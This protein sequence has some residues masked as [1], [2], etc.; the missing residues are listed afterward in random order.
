M[1]FNKNFKIILMIV[2]LFGFLPQAIFAS[3]TDGTVSGS[4]WSDQIG[5]VNFGTT[6]GNVH[7]TDSALTGYAWNE[8][9]GRINLNPTKSG[10]ANTTAGM[11]SGY[12]FAEGT[13]WINFSA[14][15]I[16]C[17]GKFVG[18]ATGD[19]IDT[20]N[21][22]CS[23]CNMY[24]D[25][26]PSSGCGNSGPQP[27]PYQ[28]PQE[29]A[30][31]QEP[32]PDTIVLDKIPP[33]IKITSIKDKYATNEEI[34]IAG[35][36]EPNAEVIVLIGDS[37]G[38]FSANEKGEWFITLGKLPEGLYHLE[39]TPRDLAGNIGKTI[40]DDFLVERLFIKPLEEKKTT[41]IPPFGPILRQLAEKLKPLIPKFFQQAAKPLPMPVVTVPK[42][43]QPSLKYAWRLLPEKPIARFVLAPLPQ[44]VKLLAQKF[45]EVGKTFSAVGVSK[46]AN[47]QKIKNSKLSLPTL[48]ETA[49]LTS[50]E[51][52]AGKIS[53][54]KA[55]PLA[56]MSAIAK[57][58]IPTDIVFLKAGGGFIDINVALSINNQG[59]SEQRIK[60]IAGK[61]LELVVKPDVP[62][63]R[64]KGYIIF[65]SKK[66][67]GRPSL[68]V[69][70]NALGYSFIFSNP[71]IALPAA[72]SL[73]IP[74]EGG[75]AGETR[76]PENLN[77]S[78]GEIGSPPTEAAE[79][80]LV[81]AEFDYIDA[82]NG[83]YT[84]EVQMP[85]VD[86]EYEIIT[87]MEYEDEI[88]YSKE[89]K[90]I[91]VVDPEGYI[92]EKSG[93]RETRVAGAIAALYWLNPETKQYELWPAKNY[94]QENP[95]TTDVRGT[96]S[97]LVPDGFY[98]LKVD[99]PGYL[100]YDGKPFEVKEGSGIH[101]NIELKTKFWFLNIVD[102]KT[103]LLA[104]VILLLLYN[105]YRDKKRERQ[106]AATI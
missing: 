98:Y 66:P 44:D 23:N 29:S 19:N 89:I 80:R 105:F 61:F 73:Q 93:D 40:T 90:M 67:S 12:A 57:S 5:W 43:A 77:A 97:F 25:W 70:M 65:K 34:I 21:F 91:T 103:F 101:I 60:A 62:V 54:V 75:K 6:N 95:Q 85:V 69:P 20:L 104:A 81:L 79:Q 82:G 2:F 52:A 36:T 86:G 64:V 45:S 59:R 24:T 9:T 72:L 48:A 94:Q 22:N 46:A 51:I 99:A 50:V 84:A 8:N 13:G 49:G 83:V 35:T 32:A 1:I 53:V 78:S 33:E 37:Y 42:I 30:P 87:V 17:D 96:Y 63:K 58:R 71:N 76:S 38:M 28:P 11:L 100:S 16:N 18:Y 26:R 47:I 74:V 3:T 10:I 88:L 15:R 92:Y 41:L 102:W 55:I 4:A 14:I 106:A 7:V 27:A 31:I 68:N 56:Q 39:F